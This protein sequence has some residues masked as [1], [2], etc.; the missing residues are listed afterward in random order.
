[1]KT[2]SD[3]FLLLHDEALSLEACQSLEEAA[4]VIA[5]VLHLFAVADGCRRMTEF[6]VVVH[7]IV[8]IMRKLRITPVSFRKIAVILHGVQI[9]L[10]GV[11]HTGK[12]QSVAEGK[13]D[14][15]LPTVGFGS[16]HDG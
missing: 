13:I 16:V 2:R 9:D 11:F 10:L 7:G 14:A 1:M 4:E 8:V 12:I 6:L 15:P 3:D 5:D